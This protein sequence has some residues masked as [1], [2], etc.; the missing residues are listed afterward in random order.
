M[1]AVLSSKTPEFDM[2]PAVAANYYPFEAGSFKPYTH[3]R[4]GIRE[5]EGVFV[6]ITAYQQAEWILQQFPQAPENIFFGNCVSFSLGINSDDRYLN[7]TADVYGRLKA[8]VCS[9]NEVLH[10]IT[11]QVV[12]DFE[13][14]FSQG[15]SEVGYY[16][17]STFL[18]SRQLIE[19]FFGPFAYEDLTANGFVVCENPAFAHFG[20]VHPLEDLCNKTVFRGE[21]LQPI[22]ITRL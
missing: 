3:F 17:I 15:F 13:P 14:L 10:D 19:S 20:S 7:I 1:Q 21:G 9:K 8:T 6:N 12:S 22:H 4:L 11:K 16:W 5:D 18:V 2:L